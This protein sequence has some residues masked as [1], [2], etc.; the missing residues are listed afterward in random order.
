[1]AERTTRLQIAMLVIAW[2]PDAAGS[3]LVAAP[4]PANVDPEAVACGTLTVPEDYD[5]PDGRQL[6]LYL[7][8]VPAVQEQPDTV[9][10]VVLAGGPGNPVSDTAALYLEKGSPTYLL[11]RDRALILL[12][13]RGTGR[14]NGLRCPA[15]ESRVALEPFYPPDLVRRC[16]DDLIANN[17]LTRFGTSEAARDLD[18]VR[19]ALEYERVDLW[20]L[21]YG[22]VLAQVYLRAFPGRV[23]SAVLVGTAPLDARLPLFHA[24]NAQRVLE[25]VFFECQSDPGC[26]AAYPGL[27]SDWARVLARLTREAPVVTLKTGDDRQAWTGE[28]RRDVFGEAFR[29]LLGSAASLRRVPWMIHQAAR[30][31][32]S[33]LLE[34]LASDEDPPFASGLFLSVTCAEATARITPEE[35]DPAVADTFLG[36]YR[37]RQQRAACEEWPKAQLPEEHFAPVASDVPVLLLV[38]DL[39]HVTPPAWSYQV[40]RGL[41]RSRVIAMPHGG[42]LFWDWGPGSTAGA[43]FDELALEFFARGDARQLDTRCAERVV[44]PPFKES[45]P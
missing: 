23:R 14:S 1:M 17:D 13:R 36:D 31:D 44:P 45:P 41:A 37:V 18:V 26:S 8:V 10:L 19:E 11:R 9:P 4:C 21:S 40:A 28:L 15:L 6:T 27:R 5:A 30:D 29:T 24:A 12:D 22:T 35:V 38:G 20:A 32:W 42:H 39:D 16:R 25:L 34:A 7:V 3:E 43:C 33:P 2:M